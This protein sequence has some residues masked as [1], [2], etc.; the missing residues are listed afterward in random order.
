MDIAKIRKKAKERAEEKTPEKA[1]VAPPAPEEKT[2]EKASVMPPAAR[3]EKIEEVPLAPPVTGDAGEALPAAVPAEQEKEEAAD[4]GETALEL[5]TFRLSRE[6]F[7]FRVS[8]VEEIVRHQ[9]ITRV[10]SLPD[11]VLGITSLRGKIIPVIDLK[12]RLALSD[13]AGAQGAAGPERTRREDG[14]KKILIIA[15]PKGLIGV[16]IDKVMGVVRFPQE[17]LLEPP[18]HLTEEELKCISGVVILEKR[19]ISTIRAEDA[20]DIEGG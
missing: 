9:S 4:T 16:T 14:K 18:A 1:P 15:G 10:P 20:L 2:P 5:L 17:N 6:E 13:T 8:E 19:F 12:K 7:A 11:Y 3:E